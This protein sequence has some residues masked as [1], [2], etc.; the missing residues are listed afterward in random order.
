[1]C[2]EIGAARGKSASYIGTA[3]KENRHG[4]L[5]SIDPHCQTS[6]NDSNSIDTFEIFRKNIARFGLEDYVVCVREYSNAAA[7]GWTR[8][9]DLLFIDGDH[10]YAEISIF[11]PAPSFETTG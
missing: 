6:W 3:L 1:M 10:T 8:P 2:V 9:I 11:G 7:K 4:K 5:Y